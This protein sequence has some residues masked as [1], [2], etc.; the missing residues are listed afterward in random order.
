MFIKLVTFLD[1][2]EYF[3]YEDNI[4]FQNFRGLSKHPLPGR[5]ASWEGVNVCENIMLF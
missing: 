1:K 3:D 4:S 2:F 5:F